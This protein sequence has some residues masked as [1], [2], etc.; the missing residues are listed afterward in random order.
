MK[1]F[2]N[3]L[4]EQFGKE[5]A[6]EIFV[7]DIMERL[8]SLADDYG[9]TEIFHFTA[10]EVSCEDKNILDFFNILDINSMDNDDVLKEVLTYLN[11]K[12]RLDRELLPAELINELYTELV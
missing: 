1:K 3:T 10:D 11:I 12:M 7:E 9:Y 2:L 5:K 4:I 8:D 6:R